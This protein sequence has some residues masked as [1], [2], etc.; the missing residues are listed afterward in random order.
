MAKTAA[1]NTRLRKDAYGHEPWQQQTII[2]QKINGTIINKKPS[3]R[4]SLG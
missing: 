3:C 4:Y 2:R 1:I